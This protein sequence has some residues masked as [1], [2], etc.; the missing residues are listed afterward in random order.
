MRS[1]LTFDMLEGEVRSDWQEQSHGEQLPRL[2][3]HIDLLRLA[4][5]F[6]ETAEMVASIG[7]ASR[8][9]GNTTSGVTDFRQDVCSGLIL[10]RPEQ[11]AQ[12]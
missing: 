5:S 12:H 8:P 10:T 6:E 7:C 11:Q 4:Q 3:L 2:W 1:A 9:R